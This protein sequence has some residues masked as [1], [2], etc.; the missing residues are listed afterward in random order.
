MPILL[1]DPDA[2]NKHMKNRKHNIQEYLSDEINDIIENE[3]KRLEHAT[4]LLQ[5]YPPDHEITLSQ[6]GAIHDA[7]LVPYWALAQ[8]RGRIRR[9]HNIP[10]KNHRWNT[11][12]GW[13]K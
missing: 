11:V 6:L 3:R 4:Y 12:K 1:D 5:Q 7:T 10:L 2:M 9:E 8:I 13:P